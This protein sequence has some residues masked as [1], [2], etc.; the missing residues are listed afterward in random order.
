[1]E[2]I[3]YRFGKERG[4]G[5]GANVQVNT[6]GK[7]PKNVVPRNTRHSVMWLTE[8]NLVLFSR[9]KPGRMTLSRLKI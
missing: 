5:G 1:V 6:K 9:N 8:I 4:E 2:G 3:R 7:V